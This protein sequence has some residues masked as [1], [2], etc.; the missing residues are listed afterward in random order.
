MRNAMIQTNQ[1]GISGGEGNTQFNVS[2]GYINQDGIVQNGN[3]KLYN[4]RT[5]IDTKVNERL[6]I[7]LRSGFDIKTAKSPLMVQE[8]YLQSCIAHC[9]IMAPI[10]PQVNMLLLG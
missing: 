3:A 10:R 7:G 1:L 9:L 5:N 2:L 6:D 4:L 8:I